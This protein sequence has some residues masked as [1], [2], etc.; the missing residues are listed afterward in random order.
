MSYQAIQDRFDAKEL[1]VLDGATGTELERR[2]VP[3]DHES[4][5]APASLEY[6]DVLEAVHLDYI[7]AGSHI[8]TANTFSSSR[9]M[10]ESAGY[11]DRLEDVNRNAIEAA[12]RARE[13]SD[14]E[15]VAV[16][17]SI[18]H[19]TEGHPGR[20]EPTPQKLAD[21]FGE[22]STIMKSTGV[23]LI[24][25]EMMYKP[26]RIEIAMT[27]ALETGLPVWAGFS[28]RAGDDGRLLSFMGEDDVP[29]DEIAKLARRPGIRA[30]GV[31]HSESN[32]VGPA[33]T[34]L[35]EHFDGPTYA[36]PDSG[37]FEMPN[38]RFED[39]IPP[40]ELKRYAG[41]WKADG[42]AAIGGCCGLTPDHIRAIAGL[43]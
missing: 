17:G 14:V 23:D 19:W 40:D 10:L 41:D 28:A 38:W 27:A 42:V 15:G 34:A 32:I 3:M 2:R 12:Q 6:A 7:R 9:P 18:S 20:P 39:V 22:I 16:A 36:Y 37:Y 43:D 29:F 13:R 31:M 1:V 25:L 24:L 4:W 21:T 11:G 26:N 5:C 8:V 33:L 35:R 30:A